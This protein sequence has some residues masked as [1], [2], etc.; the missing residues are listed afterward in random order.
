MRKLFPGYYQKTQEQL[1]ELWRQATFAFD[2]NVLL[3]LYRYQPKTRDEIL[4][5]M[6]K[7]EPRLW[8]PYQVALEFHRNRM[9]VLKDQR[10]AYKKLQDT[11]QKQRGQVLR[12]FEPYARHSSIDIVRLKE[13]VGKA[14]DEAQAVVREAKKSHPD[15]VSN[16]S[17]L[18]RVEALFSERIG[19]PYSPEQL[20]GL[21]AVAEQRFAAQIP[22]GY[23]DAG[24]KPGVRQYG[25]VILWQQLIDHAKQQH[26]PLVFVTDD[27]KSD[28]FQDINGQT[29]GPRPELTQEMWEQAGVEFHMYRPD[30]FLREASAY[31]GVDADQEVLD[32]AKETGADEAE[33]QALLEASRR[34][35]ADLY[36]QA[37]RAA[38]FDGAAITHPSAEEFFSTHHPELFSSKLTP[39]LLDMKGNL[40]R[41]LLTDSST[42]HGSPDDEPAQS[43]PDDEG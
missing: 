17:P 26:T 42:R 35:F 41:R 38:K 4:N 31:L 15:F 8:L 18:H 23:E 6:E 25:D 27:R 34:E 20:S 37:V 5:L 33:L 3:N 19:P 22:P 39:I 28:W 14:F 32:D 2:T 9:T 12:D 24:H 10:S 36:R 30:Q 11:L 43:E 1:A 40:W 21:Y 7:L 16:N 13:L 29:V